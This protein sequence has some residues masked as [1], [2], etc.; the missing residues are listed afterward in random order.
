LKSAFD[1]YEEYRN[2]IDVEAET[3]LNVE[4]NLKEL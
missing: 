2:A 1:T 3:S 4:Q